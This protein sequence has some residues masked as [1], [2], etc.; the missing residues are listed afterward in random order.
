MPMGLGGGGLCAPLPV[1]ALLGVRTGWRHERCMH[2]VASASETS[3]SPP[4]SQVPKKVRTKVRRYMEHLYRRKTGYDE[5]VRRLLRPLWSADLTE[6]YLCNAC[7]CQ[8]ML[9]RNGR[10]QELLDRLPPAL[11]KEL[12]DNLYRNQLKAVRPPLRHA[13]A[14][15]T[16]A[17]TPPP[18]PCHHTWPRPA[19]CA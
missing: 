8:E 16:A 4:T 13:H 1:G 3:G 11:S 5:Q 18:P 10:C 7:S 2:S 19:R 6:I 9:R 17:A 12:L 14:C 15:H